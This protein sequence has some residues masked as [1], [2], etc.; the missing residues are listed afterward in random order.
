LE[1]RDD[2]NAADR[3]QL[4][5]HIDGWGLAL[6]AITLGVYWMAVGWRVTTTTLDGF[7]RPALVAR[8]DTSGAH[9]CTGTVYA[10]C[11]CSPLGKIQQVSQPY[12]SG[13]SASN[14]AR[15]VSNGQP[16]CI[17]SL[18]SKPWRIPDLLQIQQIRESRRGVGRGTGD[19][20][21]QNEGDII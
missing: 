2:H 16:T 19:P 15:S 12:Q 4:L 7:G 21:P 11:A 17:T 20:A 10:R 18:R 9:S 1:S 6:V 13:G 14:W 5:Q 8:G 3:L